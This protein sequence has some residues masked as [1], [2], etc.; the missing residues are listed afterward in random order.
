MM[1]WVKRREVTATVWVGAT[2]L[3]HRN[4]EREHVDGHVFDTEPTGTSVGD[5]SEWWTRV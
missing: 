2:N 3:D 4:V 1:V 5:E